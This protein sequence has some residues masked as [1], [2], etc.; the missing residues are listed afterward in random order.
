M[1]ATLFQAGQRKS[2]VKQYWP[3]MHWPH[4]NRGPLGLAIPSA[5]VRLHVAPG[6]LQVEDGIVSLLIGGLCFLLASCVIFM[7]L[8]NLWAG[9]GLGKLC[10]PPHRNLQTSLPQAWVG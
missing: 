4:L 3:Y 9:A 10:L 5:A 2:H 7:S 1:H 8:Y 6:E